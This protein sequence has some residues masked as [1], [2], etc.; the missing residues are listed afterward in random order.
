M[1]GIDLSRATAGGSAT[2]RSGS[3]STSATGSR[4]GGDHVVLAFVDGKL[5]ASS[6]CIWA[7]ATAGALG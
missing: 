7:A 5:A 2:N 1:F 6:A 4:R 3:R